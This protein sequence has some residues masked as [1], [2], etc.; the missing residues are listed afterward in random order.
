[1][2]EAAVSDYG[3]GYV[4][5]SM[6]YDA[7]FGPERLRAIFAA[8]GEAVAANWRGHRDRLSA[9][10]PARPVDVEGWLRALRVSPFSGLLA[11]SPFGAS[12]GATWYE[13]F[14]FSFSPVSHRAAEATP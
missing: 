3:L 7:P 6:E 11:E 2:T 1:M 8:L 5:M 4:L 12:R 14:A 9:P 13:G 10:G